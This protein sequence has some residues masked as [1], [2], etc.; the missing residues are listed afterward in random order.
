MRE[1]VIKKAKR[2]KGMQSDV[3]LYATLWSVCYHGDGGH[4]IT[5]VTMVLEVM[6]SLLTNQ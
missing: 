2:G 1:R 4:D 3:S 6:T 5:I